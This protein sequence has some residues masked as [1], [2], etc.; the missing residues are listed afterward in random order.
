MSGAQEKAR[1]LILLYSSQKFPSYLLPA[2]SFAL[3]S[4]VHSKTLLPKAGKI[5]H[6]LIDHLSTTYF[7]GWKWARKNDVDLE[8]A[9]LV[10]CKY[11]AI[12]FTRCTPSDAGSEP[13]SILAS[14]TFCHVTSH[15]VQWRMFTNWQYEK[16]WWD[17]TKCMHCHKY[18]EPAFTL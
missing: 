15:T 14:L 11:E 13:K 12:R 6:S 8:V 16:E 3:R 7:Q 17:E 5:E 1:L 18:C 2:S 9:T 4:F 10:R